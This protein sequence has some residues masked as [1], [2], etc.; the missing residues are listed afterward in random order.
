[1]PCRPEPREAALRRSRRRGCRAGAGRSGC[2]RRAEGGPVQA[3]GGRAGALPGGNAW[4]PE[5]NQGLGKGGHGL[6]PVLDRS[7]WSGRRPD[8]DEFAGEVTGDELPGRAEGEPRIAFRADRRYGRTGGSVARWEE[9][10]ATRGGF[11][12]LGRPPDRAARC[13]PG[14]PPD[15]RSARRRR[16]GI[17]AR[18][19]RSTTN[20][21]AGDARWPP[22][23]AAPT[24]TGS[25]R[26]GRNTHRPPRVVPGP[27]GHV[28]SAPASAC[29][30]TSGA[31]SAADA[32]P[33]HG[34]APAVAASRPGH[35]PYAKHFRK[36]ARDTPLPYPNTVLTFPFAHS[37]QRN[38]SKE[39]S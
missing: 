23:S 29:T 12:G 37:R 30:E 13:R 15:G 8:H 19:R 35:G 11:A 27:A 6:R 16:T 14:P 38:R 17:T 3:D 36:P 9:G 18:G 33:R 10:A 22:P 20:M 28:R 31:P 1:M 39:P 4:K 34:S 26:L 7:T 21:L 25:S 2:P 24:T 32:G 5:R